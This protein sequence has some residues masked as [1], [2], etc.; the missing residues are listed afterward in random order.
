M[1]GPGFLHGQYPRIHHPVM[2]VLTLVPEGS[3][4]GPALHDQVVRFF[5]PFPVF[6]G[7][8]AALEALDG[9]AADETGDDPATG[10]AVQH[11]YLFGHSNGVVDSD[12]IA[13]DG[14]LGLLGDLGDNGGVQVDRGFSAP[15][16]RVVFVGHD[17]V[18]SH[19]VGQG[20]LVVVLVIKKVGLGGVEEGIG[21][22]QPSRVEL[23]QLGVADVALGLLGKP[24][25]FHLVFG[26]G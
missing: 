16:C 19:F 3:R 10:V 12:H 22:S 7:V 11:R 17:A 14:D 25:N 26:A 1:S 13:Q 18:E 6:R 20:I 8:D 4:L 24:V 9:A 15:V 2:V 23:R 21:E 5:E